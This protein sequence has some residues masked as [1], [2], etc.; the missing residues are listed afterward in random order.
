M[1]FYE[2]PKGYQLY[3]FVLSL[4]VTNI[5]FLSVY[6]I[7]LYNSARQFFSY[8]SLYESELYF[9]CSTLGFLEIQT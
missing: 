5:L 9:F 4:G 6:I 7:I 2:Y 3:G 8:R 1:V